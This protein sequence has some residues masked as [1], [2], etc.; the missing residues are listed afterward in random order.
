MTNQYGR[1]L[2]W[3]PIIHSEVDQG[4]MGDSI[5]RLYIRKQGKRKWEQHVRQVDR[6]WHRIATAI[7]QWNLDYSLVLLYQ[8][9]LPVCEHESEITK[10]LADA[11]SHNHRLLMDLQ[12]RGA[13]LMGTESPE[14]LLEEY[15][16]AR[17]V[18]VSLESHQTGAAIRNQR[19]RGKSLLQRRDRYIADRIADTLHPPN[20]GLLFLGA[21]HSLDAFLPEDISVRRLD[22]SMREE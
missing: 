5:R 20:K 14:L 15:E 18:L 22:Q 13:R 17:Q 3:V 9:G 1:M 11:G 4:S 19:E 6:W 12:A 21:L 7:D 10:E 16:L 8:D 2:L